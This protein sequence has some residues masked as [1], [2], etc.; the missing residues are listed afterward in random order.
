MNRLTDAP[1]A[2]RIEPFA[3][4]DAPA[5]IE[6][7]FPAQKVSFEAQRE[8]K[9]GAGQTLTALGSYWKGRKPLILVRAIVLGSLLP[10]TDGAEKDLEIFEKIMAVDEGGLARREPKVSPAE[11][12]RRIELADPWSYFSASFKGDP[13]DAAEIEGG[14]FPLEVDGYPG[15]SIRWRRD[16]DEA[17]KLDLLAK[18]L[19]TYPT[20]EERAGLCKRPEEMDQD[21]LYAPIWPAVN[22][23]LGHFGVDAH[24]HQELVE[25]LGVL[26]FGH[27]PR[28]GDTFCG[29]GS[30][31]FEAA[32]L[33]CD[34]YA[35]DLNPIACMLTWG[36]L[37]IIGASPEKRAEIERVQREVA[38]ALKRMVADHDIRIMVATDAACEG[39][40]LQ[41]LGTLIN[42]DLPW[43]PTRLEQ[44]I[45]RIKRF[46]QARS[47][48]DMLNLVHQGTVDEKVYERLSERMR[49]RYD[50][51][52]SLPDTIRDE[53]IDDIET[54]GE[55]MDQY[56]EER[57]QATGFDLRYNDTIKPSA[58]SWRD[59]AAVLARRDLENLMRQGWSG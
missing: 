15:L 10:Q 44:R 18:A 16:I 6:A 47:T 34:V 14:Q 8:R 32:R 39:L 17:D 55:R 36:A 3:L 12:A 43:N 13:E 48:V 50:L 27:R 41:T 45:G 51:F 11:I 31:P 58:A 52:G 5:L 57:R 35:S 33:G 38:E 37:N 54:L 49:N 53:W 25:Q 59:C 26:R 21:A 22:D 42:V 23:H 24:S 19:A 28:V 4:K 20:Y 30:I 9:A 2:P 56:I 7:V 1:T 40:N 29:G 46:G